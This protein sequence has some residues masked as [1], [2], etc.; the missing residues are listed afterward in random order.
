MSTAPGWSPPGT[1]A[2]GG[3]GPRPLTA[4]AA[5][6]P[7]SPFPPSTD[8]GG[9][10]ALLAEAC[11]GLEAA[12]ARRGFDKSLVHDGPPAA[13]EEYSNR[14]QLLKRHARAAI[15][16]SPRPRTPSNLLADAVG[17]AVAALAMTFA[18]FTVWLAQSHGRYGAVYL[19]I[20]VSGYV[21]KAR[22]GEAARCTR[23]HCAFLL[24]Q[25]HMHRRRPTRNP[26]R[27]FRTG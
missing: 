4:G 17:M 8:L 20:L 19:A 22:E 15:S 5:Q 13:N 2:K 1:P 23:V 7:P 9:A 11:A 12:R 27:T 18:T 3:L 26:P 16:L 21:V 24:V 10:R 25:R 14:L 6:P